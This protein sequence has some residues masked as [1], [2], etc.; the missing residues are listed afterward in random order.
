MT[1]RRSVLALLAVLVATPLLW[2]ALRRVREREATWN[3]VR[4]AVTAHE[5]VSYRGRAAWRRTE[6]EKEVEVTH[7][8]ESG[9][10]RYGW[11]RHSYVR[12]GPSS[13]MP[14]PAGWCSDLAALEDNY[15]PSEGKRVRF[16]DRLARIVALE[17]RHAGRPRVELTLDAQTSL[18]L[19]AT[20]FRH[21]GELYRVAAFR[22]I[23]IG[24][25]EVAEPTSRRASAWLGRH[26][27]PERASEAAGFALLEPDY[28]PPG[29]R[30]IDCRVKQWAGTK[31]TR[32]YT[33]G[34]TAFE[35]SQE[36]VLTPAQMETELVRR[37]GWRRAAREMRWIT[38]RGRRRIVQS[39][40][41]AKGEVVVRRHHRGAYRV[42]E[43]RVA[44]RNVTVTA[45][46]DLEAEQILHVLRSLKM[47]DS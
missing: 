12:K 4:A 28:L 19:R 5:R 7:D 6:W 27:D 43:L 2:G 35:L 21:D 40:F 41:A 34:V 47:S 3:L 22:E 44:D 13:R 30:G 16:L 15:R 31:V 29:F 37:L 14:D 42:F 32:T 23:E 8:A 20:W 18:P 11:R 1:P 25:Q 46:G 10:T 39:G 26:V 45:R 9:R 24:P 38:Y 36:P 17:P 33:D